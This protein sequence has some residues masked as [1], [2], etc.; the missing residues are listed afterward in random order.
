MTSSKKISSFIKNIATALIVLG[1]V[2]LITFAAKDG[3]YLL[4][5]F[6]MIIA[7]ATSHVAPYIGQFG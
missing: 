6:F 2:P 1:I 7:T 5:Q 4:K 3:L